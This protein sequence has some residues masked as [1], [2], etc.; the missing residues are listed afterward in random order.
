MIISCFRILIHSVCIC[1]LTILHEDFI[2]SVSY[3]YSTRLLRKVIGMNLCH[4]ELIEIGVNLCHFGLIETWS[5]PDIPAKR[6]F[7]C[8]ICPW[9]KRSLNAHPPLGHCWKTRSGC[10]KQS[11]V[12]GQT[13]MF[14]WIKDRRSCRK[15]QNLEKRKSARRK[16][17]KTSQ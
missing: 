13:G 6:A 5:F 1:K 11:T 15:D 12:I 7:P 16:Q 14:A 2:P 9:T 17:Y 10:F 8:N 4:F 3:Y